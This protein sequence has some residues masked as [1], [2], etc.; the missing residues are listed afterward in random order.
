[1]MQYNT[2]FQ[3]NP[4][5]NLGTP[6]IGNKVMASPLIPRLMTPRTEQLYAFGE[7]PSSALEKISSKF[8]NKGSNGSGKL[9]QPPPFSSLGSG[10]ESVKNTFLQNIKGKVGNVNN[11][12]EPQIKRALPNLGE[13]T[14]IG[15]GK[16]G[17]KKSD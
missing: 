7:T 12:T 9:M 8:I 6:L 1:M 10:A 2:I 3:Q 4:R 15:F 16:L 5:S 11:S 17:R 14:V 13:P